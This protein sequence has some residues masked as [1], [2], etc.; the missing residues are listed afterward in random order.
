ML[1]QKHER[2]L[3]LAYDQFAAGLQGFC[4]SEKVNVKALAGR[5]FNN[6]G[7]SVL[8]APEMVSTTSKALSDFWECKVQANRAMDFY[9]GVTLVIVLE[10]EL[11]MIDALKDLIKVHDDLCTSIQS[12]QNKMRSTN[13]PD[14]MRELGES[15][16]EKKQEL[17]IFYSGFMYFTLPLAARQ[18][19]SNFRRFGASY[20]SCQTAQSYLLHKACEEFFKSSQMSSFRAIEESN[21]GFQLL[22]ILPIPSIPAMGGEDSEGSE[23]EQESNA[24]GANVAIIPH[25]AIPNIRDTNVGTIQHIDNLTTSRN[26]HQISFSTSMNRI[27]RGLSLS[28]GSTGMS[29]LFARALLHDK[30]LSPNTLRAGVASAGE[31]RGNAAKTMENAEG[32]VNPLAARRG[33][34]VKNSLMLPTNTAPKDGLEQGIEV[35]MY[36]TR[37]ERPEYVSLRDTP[38][39]PPA[40]PSI[41]SKSRKGAA[42]VNS[43]ILDDLLEGKP[44]SESDGP[45]NKNADHLWA[46]V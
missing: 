28:E 34:A 33:S 23:D 29:G 27:P 45:L 12:V 20:V 2:A 30:G 7:H 5:T 1:I 44:A 42:P 26:H 3:Q 10:Q 37:I 36:G 15:L 4:E 25:F 6:D 39:A 19:A 46:D 22:Q 32:R 11:A 9:T 24:G 38:E 40:V 35:D 43:D 13:N 41:P 16:Q 8:Q 14:N 18:R 17:K 31:N 21:K